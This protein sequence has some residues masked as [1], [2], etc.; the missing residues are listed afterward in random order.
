MTYAV[1]TRIMPVVVESSSASLG[2]CWRAGVPSSRMNL[3]MDRAPIFRDRDPRPNDTIQPAAAK[4]ADFRTDPIRRSVAID[5]SAGF[6]LSLFC[7]DDYTTKISLS[8]VGRSSGPKTY[9]N[10]SS[11]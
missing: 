11:E 6:D 1:A 10:S 7:D 4:K 3:A 9:A 2:R 5:C 8:I